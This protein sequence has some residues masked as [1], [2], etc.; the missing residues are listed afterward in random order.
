MKKCYK[1]LKNSNN[2]NINKDKNNSIN[3][4]SQN[5]N[6]CLI[7]I[8]HTKKLDNEK[9]DSLYNNNNL[10]NKNNNNN[11]SNSLKEF[12]FLYN[13][14]I[15]K[16]TSSKQNTKITKEKEKLNT[17]NQNKNNKNYKN[18]NND[19]FNGSVDKIKNKSFS[20]TKDKT[21]SIKHQ[22]QYHEYKDKKKPKNKKLKRNLSPK[23]RLEKFLN[24]IKEH[25]IKKEQK[26]KNIRNKSLESET[27][28]MKKCPKISEHSQI[29]L[30][31]IKRKP[32]Y[33]RNPLNEEE[34]LDEKSKNFFYSINYDD[35][36]YKSFIINTPL[37]II[38]IEE[39]YKKIYDDNINW[40]KNIEEKNIKK[41]NKNKELEENI[42]NYTFKPKLNRNSINII[43]RL[44][45]NKTIDYE[46]NDGLY[47]NE[48]EMI[49]KLKLN[50]K[51]ILN[52]YYNNNINFIS[53]RSA[54]L[55]RTLSDNKIRKN[56]Y[57]NYNY[58]KKVIIKDKKMKMNY[59]MNENKYKRN[60]KEEKKELK[61]NIKKKTD[62]DKKGKDNSLLKKIRELQR[63]KGE[64]K[65]ELYKLNVREGAAWN[66]E[67]INNIIP[68]HKCGHIIEGLL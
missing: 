12:E 5:F 43:D 59:K 63:E 3:E 47:E 16:N 11:Q 19:T 33:Q 49:D 23:S 41:R 61:D 48:K 34:K 60:K 45:R 65:K 56:E 67:A 44:N 2:D 66:L 36:K 37:N 20:S 57:H 15:N 64:K 35:K 8:K 4:F 28:E 21:S 31:T 22:F 25:Q 50:L 13:D 53:K 39:K 51:P 52:H 68:K 54:F 7:N 42:E 38:I 40:K 24:S 58:K 10:T 62:L 29:L 30:K 32:L 26:I 6:K 55:I 46:I 27:S 9:S 17:K 14:S 1:L 18:N